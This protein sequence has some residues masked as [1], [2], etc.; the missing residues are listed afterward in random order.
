MEEEASEKVGV[1]GVPAEA[2]GDEMAEDQLSL[3][4]TVRFNEGSGSTVVLEL[5]TGVGAW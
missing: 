2:V 5:P 4:W 1:V 3:Y